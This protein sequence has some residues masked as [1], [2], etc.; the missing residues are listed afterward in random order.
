MC[1]GRAVPPRIPSFSFEEGPINA[2]DYASIQCTVPNGDLPI[3]IEW[4]VNGEN[5]NGY[6]EISV[7]KSG[8]RGSTLTIDPVSYKLAG[9]YTCVASNRAGFYQHTAQLFVNGYSFVLLIMDVFVT[10]LEILRSP[11]LRPIFVS[12]F[13]C[14]FIFFKKLITEV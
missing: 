8:R 3:N 9:N 4:S 6:P 12:I 10:V 7:S 5:V 13:F 14:Y 11:F 2:G 1:V